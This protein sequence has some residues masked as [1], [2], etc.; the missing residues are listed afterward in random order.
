[1]KDLFI[2]RKSELSLLISGLKS[3]NDYILVAPRRYGKTV[4]AL[5]VL[6]EI[7]KDKNFIVVDIDLMFY[8]GGSIK[9]IAEG[10]IEKILN[11]L[12]LKGK[13][14]QMWHDLDFNFRV[15]LKY[16]DLEIEPLL[17]LF[18]E[19]DEWSLLENALNLAEKVAIKE[20]KIVVMFYDEFGELAS[21][22]DRVIKAFRS[23][24]QRHKHV[25]YL[26]AGSQE[27]V[28]NKIFLDK[29]G[30]FYRFGE[31]IYLKE[32]D[33]QD[34]FNYILET[35]P[36]VH[37]DRNEIKDLTILDTIIHGLNGHPYYTAQAIKFLE[38]NKT[39]CTL[40]R[41][42]E[43]LYDELLVRERGYLSQQLLAIKGK[44]Y[45]LD[46]LRMI[47]MKINPYAELKDIR[48]QNIYRLLKWLENSGYI[49]KESRG[50]YYILDPL[51]TLLI[52]RN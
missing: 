36:L 24:L 10:I 18:K 46:I 7:R 44:Q 35:Y 25:S 32:L 27:T 5:K 41:Y 29:S 4:L 51:L 43:F 9:S 28:M 14:R 45:A 26:F 3:I 34:V 38:L 22:G 33:K 50:V 2:N 12:G 39:N 15:K 37:I 21:L 47:A 13:L 52:T 49:R 6:D 1:M 11:A 42:F 16:Q 8:S 20:N 30:A 48:E 31:L 23:V 19:G 40:Q 17:N